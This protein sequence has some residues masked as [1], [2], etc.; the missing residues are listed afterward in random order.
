MAAGGDHGKFGA[1]QTGGARARL[2][3]KSTCEREKV[4]EIDETTKL[5][6]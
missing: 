6:F 5:A 2:F 3:S 1:A 4:D